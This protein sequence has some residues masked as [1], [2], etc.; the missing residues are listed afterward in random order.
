LATARRAKYVNGKKKKG[1][2]E[3]E[4]GRKIEG[5]ENGKLTGKM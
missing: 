4:I 5:K 3:K 1:G 2:S